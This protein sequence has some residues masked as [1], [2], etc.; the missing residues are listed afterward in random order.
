VT[1]GAFMPKRL[2]KAR[3]TDPGPDLHRSPKPLLDLQL[4]IILRVA[5]PMLYRAQ[6]ERPT[7]PMRKVQHESEGF[8]AH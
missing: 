6:A 4:R 5:R 1:E 8:Y 2:Q 7:T 3:N